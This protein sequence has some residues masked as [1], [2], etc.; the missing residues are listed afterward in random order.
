[1]KKKI[2]LIILIIILIVFDILHFFASLSQDI[3]ITDYY[4]R[5]A[6]YQGNHGIEL[7]NSNLSVY[8]GLQHG[9]SV[10]ALINIIVNKNNQNYEIAEKFVR[11]NITEKELSDKVIENGGNIDDLSPVYNLE[12]Y[13][14]GFAKETLERFNK[15]AKIL[16]QTVNAGRKYNI[17]LYRSYSGL[18]S[19]VIITKD[20]NNN[21]EL[22]L[23][24][25]NKINDR[26]K[27]E[28]AEF[29]KEYNKK[30]MKSISWENYIVHFVILLILIAVLIILI[31]KIIKNHK[32]NIKNKE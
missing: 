14:T 30:L 25:E 32:K 27:I 22:L 15:V 6:I 2:L 13:K 23:N 3:Y 29:E 4:M 28:R 17:L 26:Y 1:M 11:I 21:T 12:M 7:Y 8:E 10:K 20:E 19:E 31:I 5:D 16:S 9:A 18:I 24:I